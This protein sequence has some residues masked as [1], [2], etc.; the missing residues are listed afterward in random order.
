MCQARAGHLPIIES[1]A[2]NS[3][4]AAAQQGCRAWLGLRREQAG[5]AWVWDLPFQAW[6]RNKQEQAARA[7]DEQPSSSSYECVAMD[8]DTGR[9][10]VKPCGGQ[11]QVVPVVVFACQR[12]AHEC[13]DEEQQSAGWQ[14][15][16]RW[17]YLRQ[18]LGQASWAEMRAHCR[19]LRAWVASPADSEK[20]EAVRRTLLLGQ[21]HHHHQQQQMRQKRWQHVG[22]LGVYRRSPRGLW[23]R[24]LWRDEEEEEDIGGE[25]RRGR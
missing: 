13:G 21:G 3:V 25:S 14:V 24:D 19:G 1:A 5:G 4:V 17:G 8:L 9:W 23:R 7:E 22:V 16:G 6:E 15:E 18:Q 11:K 20:N 2:E 12:P 10:A